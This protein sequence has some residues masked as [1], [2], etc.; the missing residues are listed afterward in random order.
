MASSSG[1][2]PAC[3]RPRFESRRWVAWCAAFLL[4]VFAAAEALPA[5]ARSALAH[6]SPNPPPGWAYQLTTVRDDVRM[7]ERYNPALA[8][9]RQWTLVEWLGRAPTADELEKYARSRPAAAAGGPQANFQRED[10]DPASLRL[11]REDAEWADF[12]GSFRESSTGADKML[13][14]LEIRLSIHKSPAYVGKYQLQLKAPYSPVLTVHM[15]ELFVEATFDAPSGAAPAL[16]KAHT[17]RFRGRFL[18]FP[19]TESLV[20]IYSDFAAKRAE[21]SR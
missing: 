16:P 12:T 21:L 6:F 2:F 10:I 7:V 4:P 17:S 20:L 5:Y 9:G 1:L 13:G 8:P 14:H 11:V 18:I 19:K 3:P 15:E